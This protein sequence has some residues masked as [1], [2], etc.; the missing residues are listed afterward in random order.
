M[1]LLP[2]QNEN[3]IKMRYL[4]NKN[5]IDNE[6]D[7]K[8]YRLF[9]FGDTPGFGKTR[10]MLSL[11][12]NTPHGDRLHKVLQHEIS[13][14]TEKCPFTRRKYRRDLYITHPHL[15]EQVI[16]EIGY[17]TDWSYLA[18]ENMEVAKSSMLKLIEWDNSV[19]DNLTYKNVLIVVSSTIIPEFAELVSNMKIYFYRIIFDEADSMNRIP[20]IMLMNKINYLYIWLITATYESFLNTGKISSPFLSNIFKD[21]KRDPDS[22]NNILVKTHPSIL[23]QSFCTNFNVEHITY[24]CIDSILIRRFRHYIA[25]PSVIRD[26]EEGNVRRAISTLSNNENAS[27][28]DAIRE[29]IY[30]NILRKGGVMK[31][32][33]PNS[34]NPTDTEYIII[35]N[36]FIMN[37]GNNTD[38]RSAI[39]RLKHFE[40]NVAELENVECGLCYEISE[41]SRVITPCC[42]HILCTMCLLSYFK[43]NIEIDRRPNCPFCRA[44]IIMSTIQYVSKSSESS[45]SSESPDI[46]FRTIT[47][48]EIIST[49][50]KFVKR[51]IRRNSN[52]SKIDQIIRIINSNPDGKF[53]I[54]SNVSNIY[55]IAED[56]DVP[57][58]TIG[59]DSTSITTAI[60]KYKSNEIRCLFL[61]PVSM[62]QGLNLENTT[63]IIIYESYDM[64]TMIQIRGRALRLNRAPNLSLRIHELTYE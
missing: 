25:D 62:A 41:V 8:V 26:I 61:S 19:T 1:S 6:D 38:V 18:I 4:E 28:I 16:K 10:A 57:L 30:N 37:P 13:I 54:Y 48:D 17:G 33:G 51:H 22:L 32:V 34:T 5:S 52:I 49:A 55:N 7:G 43:S 39:N 44:I 59:D 53:L 3:V 11:S 31:R 40:E 60:Q 24:R 64:Y 56:I 50:D 46:D 35:N 45:E 15:L 21:I 58:H 29:T 9:I 42:Q 20:S 36:R 63:D 27:L 2:H 14:I 47:E 12:F 23:E